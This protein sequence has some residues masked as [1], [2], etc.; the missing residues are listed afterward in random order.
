MFV[1]KLDQNLDGNYKKKLGFLFLPILEVVI[2]I[3]CISYCMIVS[4]PYFQ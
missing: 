4:E 1:H 2:V 3:K